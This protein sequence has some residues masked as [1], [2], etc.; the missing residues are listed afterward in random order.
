[1]K[2]IEIFDGNELQ[3]SPPAI[4]CQ[5]P[6]YAFFGVD[7][8]NN[9]LFVPF[10]DEI[11]SRHILLLGGIGTGKTNTFFQLTRQIQSQMTENDIAVIFDTKGDFYKEFY[12]PGDVVISNDASACGPYGVDYWNIFNEIEHNEHME[13][14]VI[15]IAKALFHSK[16]EKTNQPFF[17][18]AAKDLF[19]A[20]L[21]DT[22]R[23]GNDKIAS[24]KSLREFIEVA[25]GSALREMLER[26][27]D[28]K[29][30]ISYISDD[31]SP[32]TQG[33]LSELQQTSREILLGNFKKQGTLSMRQLVRNKGGK[34]I[35]IEY[36]IGVG[37]MLSPIYSL[38]FDLAIKE[39]LC[40]EKSD[41]SVYFITD[42]FSL[43]P[44]LQHVDDAVNFGRSLGIKFIIGIQNVNQIFD[45]YGV[46]RGKSLLSGFLT[47]VC[48][49]VN[50]EAS[51]QFIKGLHGQNRKKEVF[52]ASVQGRG[53]TEQI[54]DANVVEDWD[55]LR[56]GIG[57]AII[58]F[59]AVQPFYFKFAK[60]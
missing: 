6:K 43:I 21:M 39:A 35:F 2:E 58:G 19:S 53:I 8:G 56:L 29:A 30:M 60:A 17:P 55:V 34:F 10:D 40:R 11:M 33:V 27:A 51:R 47:S 15:E 12:R 57:E 4:N 49:R 28:F 50:D 42:E 5:R 54:R 1:M 41:G 16:I 9:R 7:Q 24:N 37:G 45:G 18:N 26:N 52:S 25:T 14:N 38:L 3:M 46:D 48:F 13:E 36:D 32:Q 23:S 22:I 31:R 59:P 20:I 44:N